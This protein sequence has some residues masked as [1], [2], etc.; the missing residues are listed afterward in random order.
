MDELWSEDS[1]EQRAQDVNHI[2]DKGVKL[3][4]HGE[5][6]DLLPRVERLARNDGSL[7]HLLVV[8]N[9]VSVQGD[10]AKQ[11]GNFQQKKH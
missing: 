11:L 9:D 10:V 7:V 2:G 6:V 3:A 4:G 5:Q 1:V 8:V